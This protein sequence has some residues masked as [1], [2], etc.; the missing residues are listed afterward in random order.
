[1]KK[2]IL[3]VALFSGY[4]AHANPV[5]PWATPTYSCTLEQDVVYGQGQVAGGMKDLKLDLYIPDVIPLEG[6]TNQFPLMVIIHGGGFTGGDKAQN[7]MF[8][9]A[10]EYAERGW[11]VASINYRLFGDDPTPSARVDALYQYTKSPWGAYDQNTR[12]AI[13]SVDDTLKAI[14][15]LQARPDV[16]ASWTTLTGF[17]AGGFSALVTGYA[18][19]DHGINRPP[20]ALVIDNWGWI[21]DI[22][23]T[24]PISNTDPAL[25]I[26][27]G[28]ADATI[29]FD[30]AV[31]VEAMAM[32]APITLDFQAIQDGSHSLYL[33]E[34]IASTGVTL[35]Q[36][37]VDYHHE[38]LF[39]GLDSGPQPTLPPPGC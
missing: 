30:R 22:A 26:I 16:K 25:L 13:S 5:V 39:Q 24:N 28:T 12:A 6:T 9:Y 1:M 23:P 15:F 11:L 36:R 32:A 34:V 29:N 7:H 20:V 3:L 27:H 8:E 17:S 18:L 19:D 4:H 37:S 31:A 38:T 35:L 10:L 2:L 21:G 33:L 14:E